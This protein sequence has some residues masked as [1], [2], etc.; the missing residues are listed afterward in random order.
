[1]NNLWVPE[2][3][4]S[5]NFDPDI[6]LSYADRLRMRTPGNEG[7][8]QPH[9]DGG[10]VEVPIIPS[11]SR[12][13]SELICAFYQRWADPA[14]QKVYEHVFEGEWEKHDPFNGV[15]RVHVNELPSPNVCTFFRTYQVT[16]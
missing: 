16:H 2:G 7:G 10:S 12:H 15:L 1:L 5:L 6:N 3:Q 13:S 14:Y 9:L 8:L 11:L 4:G